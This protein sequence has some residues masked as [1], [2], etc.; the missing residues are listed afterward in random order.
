[1]RFVICRTFSKVKSLFR[2]RLKT[3]SFAG[4]R[5]AFNAPYTHTGSS[6]CYAFSCLSRT[7]AKASS[8]ISIVSAISASEM[9]ALIK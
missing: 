9:A 1:M 4:D 8:A 2:S 7:I 3:A 6:P 5:P